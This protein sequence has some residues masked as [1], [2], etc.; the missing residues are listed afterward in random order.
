[1]KLPSRQ[2]LATLGEVTK[3]EEWHL[4][5]ITQVRQGKHSAVCR[6][7]QLMEVPQLNDY[8]LNEHLMFQ[9]SFTLKRFLQN[10]HQQQHV[11]KHYLCLLGPPLGEV[12]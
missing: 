12:T 7:M 11:T 6:M 8:N 1:V 10:Y 4:C 5:C 9:L 2:Q 3:K